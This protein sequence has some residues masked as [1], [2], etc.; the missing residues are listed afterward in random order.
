MGEQGGNRARARARARAWARAWARGKGKG[1][2]RAEPCAGEKGRNKSKG[3]A[4]AQGPG[5]ASDLQGRGPFASGQQPC[6]PP[7]HVAGPELQ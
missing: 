2:Y 1:Q 4:V 5:A 6:R 3:R 7:K